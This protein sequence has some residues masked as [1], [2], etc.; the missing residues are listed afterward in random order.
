MQQAH[1]NH[2]RKTLRTHSKHTLYK[3]K[4]GTKKPPQTGG[5]MFC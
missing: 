3:K 2:R 5:T 1:N 4:E